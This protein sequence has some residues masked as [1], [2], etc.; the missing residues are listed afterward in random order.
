MNRAIDWMARNGVAANLLMI[1]LTVIGVLSA[2][3]VVQE[4]F[5]EF[6]LDAVQVRVEYPGSSPEEIEQSIVQRVED[7]IEGI[8]GID[9]ITATAAE[10]FGVVTAELKRGFDVSEVR[11][12]IK[13]EVDR[14]TAFPQDAEEPTVAELTNRQQ[15]IQIALY[16]DVSERTLKEAAKRLDNELTAYPII[17]L[18]EIDGVRDY[19]ISV[20]VSRD[21]LR[22]HNLTLAEV[23]ALVRQG[24]LDLPGG[25]IET[26]EEQILIRTEGQNYTKQDFEDIVLLSRNDGTTVRLGD[27]A[28]VED[29]FEDSEL[30]TRFNGQPA[31]FLKIFRTGDEQVLAVVD[32]VRQHLD[33][34]VKPS[35]P[36]GLN[37]SIWKNDAENLR[38]RLSLLIKNGLLGLVLVIVALGLFLN[39]RLAFWSSVGI[40]IAF[41]A[42]FAVMIVLDVS[43][44]LLSLF[45]FILSIGIVVDDAIVV[46]ENVFAE[47]EKGTPPLK[48][49]IKGAQRVATPVTFAILT[50]VVAF[51]PLLF[52]SGTIGK[53]LGDIPTIVI[54]VLLLSLVEVLVILPNHLSHVSK[55]DE[56]EPNNVFLKRLKQARTWV[57][58]RLNAFIEG[59]LDRALRFATASYGLVIVSGVAAMIMLV[60]LVAGGY[61]RFSFFPA[62]V[63]EVVTARLEMPVGVSANETERVTQYLEETGHRS[64]RALQA[65]LP[66][67]HPGILENVFVSVGRQ[68]S[69]NSGPDGGGTSLVQANVAE[70]SFELSDPEERAVGA[71]VFEQR[72]REE[73]GS[74]PGVRSLTFT[75]DVVNIGAP[76][77]VELSASDTEQLSQAVA[78][79]EDS[80]RRFSGVFDIKNDQQ[81]GKREI[82][83]QLTD[84]GRTLGLTLQDLA[85]Q[86]RS[87]FFGAEAYRLQR[88]QDE[89]RVFARL[90]DEERE[91]IDDLDDFRIRTPQGAE[92]PLEEVATTAMGTGPSQINRRDGRRVI[93]ITA[94]VN[95]EI[96]TGQEVTSNL[97][98]SVLPA[99]KNAI[100]NVEYSFQGEQRQQRQAQGSL[101]GGF[102]VALFGIYALLAIP[103]RSY[104]QPLVIMSTIP[105]AWFGAIFGHLLFDIPLGLLSIFGLVGLSGVIVNDALVMIDFANEERANGASWNTA[106]IHAGKARFR[107]I[108]LTSLTTFLGVFPIIIEQSVQAQF[109]IPMA[110]S[111]GFGIL[112]GTAVLMLMVPALAMLQHD[113]A[114][115]IAG[116]LGRES[117]PVNY[118]GYGTGVAEAS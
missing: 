90:P 24:S 68:P 98:A 10:N 17:S 19:E 33:T 93:T 77:S 38:S 53:L 74:L 106:L 71:R 101:I 48:A 99:V 23:A 117:S 81:E 83:L 87:A 88:G 46:G 52:V 118:G 100:P 66:D 55:D 29:G 107:P 110:V 15:A 14:I 97:R 8:E 73:S 80:L 51:M 2:V 12:D 60:G 104:V 43:V 92:I 34:E 65:D 103:F 40:F 109:L 39:P 94:D 3:T 95:E 114:A 54:I 1:F 115:W 64:I 78:A 44:N 45:G 82:E 111:L 37:V 9:R 76:V 85:G 96:V 4:V 105:F 47:Q 13:Q 22:A 84:A 36:A 116:L 7:R 58:A 49:A 27:V 63:G 20:E 56:K 11:D 102:L 67:G 108:L 42:T 57:A 62:V 91:S 89:V 18:I 28:R 70:V 26:R 72:W 21:A 50:T 69:A 16:G 5:P 30:I 32:Q 31:A 75:S 112:F 86:V 61:I 59:P 25:E 35:L 79:V 6:S 113:V 41:I